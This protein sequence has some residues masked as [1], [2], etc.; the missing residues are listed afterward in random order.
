MAL[1]DE[2]DVKKG[3]SGLAS[4]FNQPQ[5]LKV[6]IIFS[7]TLVKVKLNLVFGNSFN[8]V[9]TLIILSGNGHSVAL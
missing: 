4:S 7:Q 6:M 8:S 2:G 9:R 3:D 1:V 5:V